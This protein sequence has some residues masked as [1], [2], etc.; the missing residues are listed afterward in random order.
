MKF[1]AVFLAIF[2]FISCSFALKDAVCG[3]AHAKN[4]NGVISCLGFM[5]S[6]SYN[7]ESNECTEFVYGGC[8]G[9]DNRFESKEACEQKCKE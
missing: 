9:N 7:V 1:F 6:W 3:Q 5:K 2:A 8:M 4:G